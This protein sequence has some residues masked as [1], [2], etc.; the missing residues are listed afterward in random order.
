[1]SIQPHYTV[2]MPPKLTMKMLYSQLTGLQQ[3]NLQLAARIIELERQVDE[4]LYDRNEAAKADLSS[5]SKTL[6]EE[7]A[8]F[9]RNRR[10]EEIVFLVTAINEAASAQ[11]KADVAEVIQDEDEPAAYIPDEITAAQR[12]P[13]KEA[14]H[15]ARTRAPLD[16]STL[17]AAI[18]EASP[19][20]EPVQPQ[21][22]PDSS[23]EAAFEAA[24][25]P[26]AHI[27]PI[28][29]QT[30]G[31]AGADAEEHAAHAPVAIIEAAD[32]DPVPVCD[33]NKQWSTAN[34]AVTPMFVS[35]T[36]RY[37]KKKNGGLWH[38]WFSWLSKPERR[39]G[40]AS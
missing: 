15:A 30:P 2:T 24:Y 20:A 34:V 35:R 32:P 13:D 26:E 10:P 40:H 19:A 17:V 11:E 9:T 25:G 3:E 31:A 6:S 38:K 23:F 1:M 33:E 12:Q 16:I 21:Q 4:I 14:P 7:A 28:P 39:A 8:S 29:G 18:A 5:G 37:H 27:P 36:N 22:D